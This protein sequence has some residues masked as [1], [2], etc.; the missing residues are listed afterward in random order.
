[1]LIYESIKLKKRE[2]QDMVIATDLTGIWDPIFQ[3]LLGCMKG[4]VQIV[5]VC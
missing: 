4:D 3:G 1:M 2:G 5:S